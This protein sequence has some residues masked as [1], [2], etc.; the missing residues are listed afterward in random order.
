MSLSRQKLKEY[1]AQLK[2]SDIG[3]CT[4]DDGQDLAPYLEG[5][6]APFCAD[7]QRRL[8][9]KLLLQDAKTVIMCV[10]NY[11]AGEQENANLSRY[12]WGRDYHTVIHEKLN[13]LCAQIKSDEPGVETVIFA[14]RSPLCDKYLAYRAG[15]GFWGENSL[16]I[17]P[18]FGSYIFLGGVVSNLEL[19]TDRPLEGRCAGCHACRCACPAGAIT[20]EGVDGFA[21]VSY[22]TQKKGELS[23]VQEAVIRNA[24][25]AWGCDICSEV[26]P[27]NAKPILT[28]IEEFRCG[29]HVHLAR[30]TAADEHE[31]QRLCADKAY[32]WRG[33]TVLMRNLDVLR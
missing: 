14:D 5:R 30:E 16:L 32:T 8:S 26:C 12:V 17:H 9:P 29:L 20:D 10:F 31:W 23:P 7:A 19:P 1:A 11:Y 33:R 6:R 3:V 27:H 18:S 13:A 28:D 25:K 22:L 15:L 2:I 24:G 4:A 21:C